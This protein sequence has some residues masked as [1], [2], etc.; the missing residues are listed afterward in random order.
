MSVPPV[1]PSPQ[2]IRW[3][4]TLPSRSPPFRP[5]RCKVKRLRSRSPCPGRPPPCKWEG[6]PVLGRQAR[7][8]PAFFAFTRPRDDVRDVLTAANDVAAPSPNTA[9]WLGFLFQIS[10]IVPGQVV[11]QGSFAYTAP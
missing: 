1:R 4:A 2:V 5:P 9:E 7:P 11:W 10:S 8:T 3:S 6:R